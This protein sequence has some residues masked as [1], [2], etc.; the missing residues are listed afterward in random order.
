MIQ[1]KREEASRIMTDYTLNAGKYNRKE[2]QRNYNCKD[3]IILL[4]FMYI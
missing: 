2:N 4:Y 1:G 3:N